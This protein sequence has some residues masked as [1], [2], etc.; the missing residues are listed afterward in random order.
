MKTLYV[1]RHAKSSWDFPDLGDLDRPLLEKGVEAATRV[2]QSLAEDECIVDA[3]YTSPAV[4]ALNTALIHS[5]I[6]ELPENRIFIRKSIY[7]YGSEGMLQLLSDLPDQQQHVMV[8][9]HNPTFTDLINRFV[10]KP[11]EN[12]QTSGVMKIEF[13]IESWIEIKKA[14]A[15]RATYY[16]RR[17]VIDLNYAE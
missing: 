4:R 8:C 2:A 5:R 12:L 7:N 13:E 6:L 16:K 11:I 15:C 1:A 9:G 3:I 10:T 17:R 14:M